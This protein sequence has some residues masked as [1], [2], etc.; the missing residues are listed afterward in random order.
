MPSVPTLLPLS[1]ATGKGEGV[2]GLRFPVLTLT[3]G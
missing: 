2:G 3:P 1:F